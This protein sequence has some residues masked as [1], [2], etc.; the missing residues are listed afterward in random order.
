M[1]KPEETQRFQCSFNG[2]ITVG[3]HDEIEVVF[4]FLLLNLIRQNHAHI[5]T[6]V[7]WSFL[8]LFRLAIEVRLRP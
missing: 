5:E 6:G 3:V 7:R 4:D 1:P 2:R 8:Q